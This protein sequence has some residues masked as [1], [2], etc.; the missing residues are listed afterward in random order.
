MRLLSLCVFPFD[1][2][3]RNKGAS[4]KRVYLTK[5]PV[6]LYSS[7]CS[8]TTRSHGRLGCHALAV[9]LQNLIGDNFPSTYFKPVFVVINIL[10]ANSACYI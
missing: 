5:F 8:A 2:H 1:E 3:E 7:K 4:C 9:A 10:R 6:E